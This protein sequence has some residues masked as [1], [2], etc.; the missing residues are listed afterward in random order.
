MLAALRELPEL[1]DVTCDQQAIGLELHL[2]ID[3]DTRGAARASRRRPSTTRCTTRSGSGIVSTTFTQLNQYRVILEVAPATADAPDALDKLYVR[4]STGAPVAAVGVRALRDPPGAAL[5]RPPGP[6]PRGDAL[7][8]HRA[9]RVARRGG[10]RD[11]TARRPSSSRRRRCA[12][13]SRARR[14]R[15]ASRWRA[16]RFLVLAALI[17]VYIVLGVL[18]ESYIHPI[19]ILSTLPSAGVGAILALTSSASRST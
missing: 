1:R 9:R 5:D 4:S 17:T 13:R 8:Q 19:T 3:R 18:Y 12:R 14:R 10:R 7:V 6:V 15:S 11:R 2:A 16:S